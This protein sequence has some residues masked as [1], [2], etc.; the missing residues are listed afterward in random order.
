MTLTKTRTF[1]AKW[2]LVEID[3]ARKIV[4]IE[5][6]CGEAHRSVTNAAEEVCEHV[7]NLSQHPD[8]RLFYCDTDGQWDEL[9]HEKGV[10][11]GFA[12]GNGIQ[13]SGDMAARIVND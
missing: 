12:F 2:E 13:P 5:D 10:F 8:Y 4:F 3:D 7:I 1:P 11:K 6:C 9:L